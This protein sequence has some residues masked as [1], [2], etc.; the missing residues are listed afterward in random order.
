MKVI[1]VG[2]GLAGCAAAW[3]LEK[4][5]HDCVLIEASEKAGGRNAMY[6]NR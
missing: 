6:H 2:A 5:G 1:I 3:A 4:H